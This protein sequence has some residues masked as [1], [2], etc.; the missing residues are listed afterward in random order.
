VQKPLKSILK[1]PNLNPDDSQASVGPK[2]A[3]VSFSNPE[4]DLQ[5]QEAAAETP[6]KE[7]ESQEKSRKKRVIISDKKSSPSKANEGE[8]KS[9]RKPLKK[10]PHKIKLQ[11]RNELASLLEDAK[12]FLKGSQPE[13]KDRRSSSSKSPGRVSTRSAAH[14]LEK[15]IRQTKTMKETVDEGKKY[16]K[17]EERKNRKKK[18]SSSRTR[19]R[20]AEPGE[21]KSP[22]K[23]GSGSQKQKNIFDDEKK[24]SRTKT[25]AQTIAEGQDFLKKQEKAEK[26]PIRTKTMQQTLD[27]AKE[28]LKDQPIESKNKKRTVSQREPDQNQDEIEVI[29]KKQ[30]G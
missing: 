23:S 18:G 2:P 27:E 16:L 21:R 1:S 3:R 8:P 10:T 11:K 25:I 15:K 12:E 29:E 4:N 5:E 20:S 14:K 13:K 28:I 6:N 26:K 22:S 9:P 30:F 24:I 7:G 19:S 17:K